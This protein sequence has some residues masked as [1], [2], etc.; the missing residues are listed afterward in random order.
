MKKMKNQ[1]LIAIAFFAAIPTASNAE[2]IWSDESLGL[3][4]HVSINIQDDVTGGCWTNMNSIK[5]SARLKLEQ[6]GVNV[7]SE[8]LPGDTPFAYN[9]DIYGSGMRRDSSTCVGSFAIRISSL[10]YVE[11]D[12]ELEIAGSTLIF[13]AGAVG[14]GPTLN[15][16][17][18]EIADSQITQLSA[19][20][21]SQRRNPT[22]AAAIKRHQDAYNGRPETAAE[23]AQRIESLRNAISE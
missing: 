11:F 9:I 2:S 17:F 10:G 20:I 16:N 12:S 22:I 15:K 13:D 14:Y 6:S 1:N 8:Q 4:K 23:Q 21:I 18:K 7:Y 19:E 5:Q 3:I